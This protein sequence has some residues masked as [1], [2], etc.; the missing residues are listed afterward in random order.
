VHLAYGL[1]GVG[2][3]SAITAVALTV[4]GRRHYTT[5]TEGS[6]CIA[7][8]NGVTCDDLGTSAIHDAQHLADV[9]TGFALGAAALAGVAVVIYVT[10]P[11]D[12]IFV[13]PQ[14]SPGAMTITIGGSF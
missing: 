6:H 8:A 7:G 5:A 12:R 13:R 9:G 4:V 3:A 2:I 11:R 14:A 1:G 10:A